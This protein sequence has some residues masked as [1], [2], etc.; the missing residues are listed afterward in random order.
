MALDN[1]AN[2]REAIKQWSHRN[3]IDSKSADCITMAEQE[4]YYGMNP[5]RLQEMITFDDVSS[6]ART[7]AIPSGLLELIK[8]EVLIDG[9]Y[10]KLAKV[11]SISVS[12]NNHKGVPSFYT[13][14]DSIFLDIEPDTSYD[15]RITY[16]KKPDALSDAVPTNIVLQKYP[17]AY[18]FG[19]LASAFMYTNDSDLA[20]Q[21]SIRMR[22]VVAKANADSDNMQYGDNPI[23]ITY[24]GAP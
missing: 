1:Y 20:N 24:G 11:P 2:L 13:I 22:D 3:D 19:G 5:L 18:L 8:I 4:L 12:E 17:T 15:F 23:Q 9:V 7:L 10:R 21:Y 14:L 16:Y 6:S